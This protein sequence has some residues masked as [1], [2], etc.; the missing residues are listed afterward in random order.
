MHLLRQESVTVN[1]A[2]DKRRSEYK[3][4]IGDGI[5]QATELILETLNSTEGVCEKPP[6]DVLVA[7]LADFS[8]N[9]RARQREG[10]PA[11]KGPGPR[12]RS[13]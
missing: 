11:G 13:A 1:T 5:G 10:W 4:G 7:E 3:I 8:V 9:I 12:P 2:F 6:P